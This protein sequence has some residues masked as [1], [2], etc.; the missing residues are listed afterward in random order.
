MNHPVKNTE[1]GLAGSAATRNRPEVPTLVRLAGFTTLLA[2]VFG[3]T[4]LV[5][6]QVGPI[7]QPA[8]ADHGNT[9]NETT[10]AGVGEA[11]DMDKTADGHGEHQSGAQSTTAGGAGGVPGGLQVSQ[12]GYTFVLDR[13]AVAA[14]TRDLSFRIKGPDGQPVTDYEVEHEKELHLIAVRRDFTG[15]QHVHPV[16]AADGTWSTELELTGGT[17]RLF[18]D[19]APTAT[20]DADTAPLT[21]GADL[22]VTGPTGG[23]SVAETAASGDSRVDV[24]DGYRVQLTGDLAAGEESALELAVTRDGAPVTDLQPYLGARG[25]LVALREGDLAYLHVHPT[26]DAD[27]AGNAVGF[28]AAVPSLG[29]YRLYLDFRVDDLVRTAS[30]ALTAA[31][32]GTADDRARS[33]DVGDH[34]KDQTEDDHTH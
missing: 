8:A 27:A 30:F 33:G 13:S 6:G 14:G 11:D 25:H 34:S 19:F 12:D 5:G 28:G 22:A 23:Q 31:D 16:R 3:V 17:W 1:R 32:A 20:D 24:V 10:D 2:A 4:L 29:G 26:D 15:F 21:L 9:H 7:G 18:A